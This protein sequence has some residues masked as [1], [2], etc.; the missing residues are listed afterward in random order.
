VFNGSM[1]DSKRDASWR[2]P[3]PI[4]N[5]GTRRDTDFASVTIVGAVHVRRRT[6][7]R[8]STLE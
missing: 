1:R 8:S 5:T 4:L 3:D 2:T 7:V 6:T